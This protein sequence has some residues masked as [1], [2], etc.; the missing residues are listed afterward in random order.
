VQDS[1]CSWEVVCLESIA[2]RLPRFVAATVA[3]IDREIKDGAIKQ[4][5]AEVRLT[6]E[7]RTPS[8]R[9]K[10][11]RKLWEVRFPAFD[12]HGLPVYRWEYFPSEQ[13]AR[14]AALKWESESELQK[15]VLSSKK[16][17]GWWTELWLKDGLALLDICPST[18][19]LYRTQA[20]QHVVTSRFVKI[21]LRDVTPTE[22]KGSWPS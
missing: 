8:V 20:K 15:P 9:K 16:S 2:R 18:V 4:K 19:D 21:P 7:E 14:K 1:H 12:E 13:A 10:P 6:R 5:R 22:S 3:R 11:G 17:V